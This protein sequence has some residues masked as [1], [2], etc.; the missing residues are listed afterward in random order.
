MQRIVHKNGRRI[1]GKDQAELSCIFVDIL[2]GKL[3]H[4]RPALIVNALILSEERMLKFA[5]GAQKPKCPVA[6]EFL[7]DK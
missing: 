4:F 2:Y 7:N 6:C 3:P 5:V 1:G